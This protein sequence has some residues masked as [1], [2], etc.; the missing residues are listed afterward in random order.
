MPLSSSDASGR[1]ISSDVG[2]SGVHSQQS[3]IETA[4]RTK[5]AVSCEKL[6]TGS[7]SP[8]VL[9]YCLWIT[10]TSFNGC[11]NSG[12]ETSNA[13]GDMTERTSTRAQ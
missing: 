5:P 2:A 1:G 12:C 10:T 7:V 3:V 13:F 8:L 4:S 6:A 11:F 9:T